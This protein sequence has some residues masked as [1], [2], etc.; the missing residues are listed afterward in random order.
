M[1]QVT[2]A[3]LIQDNKILIPSVHDEVRW[4][5]AE[6]PDHFDFAPADLPI[7]EKLQR[8]MLTKP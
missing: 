8:R 2:A 4:V 5:L 7:V 6:Q 3:I 1:K